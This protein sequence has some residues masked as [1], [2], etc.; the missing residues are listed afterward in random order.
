MARIDYHPGTQK[1]TRR[2]DFLTSNRDGGHL[3]AGKGDDLIALRAGA[4]GDTGVGGAGEDVFFIIPSSGSGK[5]GKSAPTIEDFEQG[6]DKIDLSPLLTSKGK[7]GQKSFSWLGR[8]EFGSLKFRSSSSQGSAPAAQVR[9]QNNR[10]QVDSDGDGKPEASVAVPGVDNLQKTDVVASMSDD[11]VSGL[12][13]ASTSSTFKGIPI[14]GSDSYISFN[15]V[16]QPSVTGADVNYPSTWEVWD[17]TASDFGG[18]V[19][20]NTNFG[21]ELTV[22]TGNETG[23]FNLPRVGISVPIVNWDVDPPATASAS[24]GARFYASLVVEEEGRNKTFGL[25]GGLNSSLNFNTDRSGIISNTSKGP[26]ATQTGDDLTGINFQF[27]G[28]Q[29]ITLQA[30]LGVKLPVVDCSVQV[31][32]F[33]PKFAIPVTYT[34]A[35]D[36]ASY[37]TAETVSGVVNVGN[38]KC[39]PVNLTGY[40]DSIAEVTIVQGNEIPL[41]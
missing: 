17:W 3:Y 16:F 1:G 4:S 18:S 13:S 33:G 34:I 32:S 24:A 2:S 20:V 15:P 37:S 19:N 14:P 25:N 12:S 27:T 29:I 39:G 9:F 26:Y 21:Y 40:Q 31:A 7:N 41:S 23:T 8:K 28:S 6:K 30:G 22:Q 38:V 5:A 35:S 11:Q 10:L 36:A